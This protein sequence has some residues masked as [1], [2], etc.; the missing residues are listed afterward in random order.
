MKVFKSKIDRLLGTFLLLIIVSP[1]LQ[2]S[3]NFSSFHTNEQWL[4]FAVHCAVSLIV[5][6][7]SLTLSYTI[8]GGKLVVTAGFYRK[9]IRLKDIESVQRIRSYLSAPALSADRLMIKTRH[10]QIQVS[11]KVQTQFVTALGLKI[12]DSESD[13]QAKDRKR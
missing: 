6:Y 3:L 4:G 1:V 13:T 11:P 12:E 9:E 10:D 2:L 5:A 8:E 7:V